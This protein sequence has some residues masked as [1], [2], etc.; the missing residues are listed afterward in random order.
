MK[1][2]V[3]TLNVWNDERK[4]QSKGNY[5]SRNP[6]VRIS[7]QMCYHSLRAFLD[8]PVEKALQE[9]CL[10]GIKGDQRDVAGP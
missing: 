1:V 4:F 3:L 9:R 7:G 10:V 2:R 6:T 5:Y 8:Q